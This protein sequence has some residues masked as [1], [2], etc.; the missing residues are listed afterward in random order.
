M[1]ATNTTAS[2]LTDHERNA[3]FRRSK[4]QREMLT[5][6][7][8]IFDELRLVA[9]LESD[10]LQTSESPFEPIDVSRIVRA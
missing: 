1:T 10:V 4:R 2:R 6:L 7:N 8:M 9:V 5:T 3:E